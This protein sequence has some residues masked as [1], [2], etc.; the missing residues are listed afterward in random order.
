MSCNPLDE[1][2]LLEVVDELAGEGTVDFETFNDDGDGDELPCRDF[3]HGTV[4][5]RLVEDDGVDGLVLDLSLG[6]LL[7]L[8]CLSDAARCFS[9][10]LYEKWNIV[11]ESIQNDTKPSIDVGTS[12]AVLCSTDASYR[13]LATLDMN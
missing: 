12:G 11:S 3:L 13:P 2:L 5:C 9:F 10:G 1:V 4:V 8:G 6:P 7:L